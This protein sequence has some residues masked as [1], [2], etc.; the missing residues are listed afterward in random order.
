MQTPSAKE[1]SKILLDYQIN[2]ITGGFF[3]HQGLGEQ[4]AEVARTDENA[5]PLVKMLCSFSDKGN[6]MLSVLAY[7]KF[8]EEVQQFQ[9]TN[10]ISSVYWASVE[11]D[12]QIIRFPKVESQ[13]EF[14]PQDG[15]V[16]SRNK[17]RV[18]NEFLQFAKSSNLQWDKHEDNEFDD[19][20]PVDFDF[21]V[22]A[23]KSFDYITLSLWNVHPVKC[24]ESLKILYWTKEYSLWLSNFPNHEGTEEMLRISA[25]LKW[26]GDRR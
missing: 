19:V 9:V 25:T 20:V 16:L 18:L 3:D 21:I 22:E 13:L 26:S 10:N 5:P 1:L 23:A 4:I 14:M 11:W 2:S 17:N 24:A 12:G 6:G 15:D 7:W 8:R